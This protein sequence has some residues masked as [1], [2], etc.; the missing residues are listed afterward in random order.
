M[1]STMMPRLF[2][3]FYRRK[4]L[5]MRMCL[6]GLWTNFDASLIRIMVVAYPTAFVVCSSRLRLAARYI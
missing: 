2:L 6:V 1:L 5:M 3:L 4:T